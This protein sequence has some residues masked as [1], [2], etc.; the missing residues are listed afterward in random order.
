M[1]EE[2]PSD[3][4]PGSDDTLQAWIDR[5]KRAHELVEAVDLQKVAEHNA[6]EVDKLAS[7]NGALQDLSEGKSIDHVEGVDEVVE[8]LDPVARRKA[9]LYAHIDAAGWTDRLGRVLSVDGN[10]ASLKPLEL[11]PHRK[12]LPEFDLCIAPEK[13]VGLGNFALFISAQ[14]VFSAAV[15]DPA[16]KHHWRITRSRPY[17]SIPELYKIIQL[18]SQSGDEKSR[19]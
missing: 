4:Q 19:G 9:Q 18:F 12:G 16:S 7:V 3:P 2:Q 14:G 17:E 11:I 13:A 6:E 10:N 5:A 15:N 1:S 8:E